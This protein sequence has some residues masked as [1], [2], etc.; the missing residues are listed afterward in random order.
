MQLKVKK[1]IE[2]TVNLELPA[3]FKTGLRYLGILNENQVVN[4][5]TSK[6][7]C[8]YQNGDLWLFKSTIDE[9]TRN[10]EKVTEAD[11][12]GAHED[13]LRLQSLKPVLVYINYDDLNGIL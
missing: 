13:F 12:I 8:T 5:S 11:F 10:W 3:Y 6:G 7:L 1:E 2:E 9:A 4:F